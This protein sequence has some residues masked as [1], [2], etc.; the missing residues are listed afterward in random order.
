[1]SIKDK[2][3]PAGAYMRS[4]HALGFVTC[5]GEQKLL[6]N[7]MEQVVRRSF[8]VAQTHRGIIMNVR[9]IVY[10][11]EKH[12]RGRAYIV[13]ETV[14]TCPWTFDSQPLPIYSD[15]PHDTSRAR[16]CLSH[17]P[18]RPPYSS[19]PS[20]IGVNSTHRPDLSLP[21]RSSAHRACLQQN[22][23]QCFC[24]LLQCAE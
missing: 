8:A 20:N 19:H 7:G 4:K 5:F 17:C 21:A 13:N 11:T 6:E 23:R 2:L 1:M 24:S 10:V 18:P 9:R 3:Q 15:L 12:D 22:V 16:L 14:G